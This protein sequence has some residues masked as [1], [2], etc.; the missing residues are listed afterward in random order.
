[1]SRVDNVWLCSRC[2]DAVV[3]AWEPTALVSCAI[4]QRS[5]PTKDAL[6]VEN[7]LRD[8]LKSA[9]TSSI[10]SLHDVWVCRLCHDA[11]LR[12]AGIPRKHDH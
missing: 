1:M 8:D 2:T 11:V 7:W 10:K 4:C 9:M 5:E 6:R 3:A 12:A